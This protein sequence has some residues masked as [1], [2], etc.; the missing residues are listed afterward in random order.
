[1]VPAVFGGLARRA[2]FAVLAAV[3][4]L[5]MGGGEKSSF[6]NFSRASAGERDERGQGG[7]WGGG[8]SGNGW[9]GGNWGGAGGGNSGWGGGNANS[10]NGNGPNPPPA[11]SSGSGGP[12]GGGN[13]SNSGTHNES[14]GVSYDAAKN[15]VRLHLKLGDSGHS[16]TATAPG[17]GDFDSRHTDSHGHLLTSHFLRGRPVDLLRGHSEKDNRK[18][19]GRPHTERVETASAQNANALQLLNKAVNPTANRYE[20]A[21]SPYTAKPEPFTSFHGK[22]GLVLG[23]FSFLPHEIL[24]VDIDEPAKQRIRALGFTVGPAAGNASMSRLYAPPGMDAVH[25][26]QLLSKELPGH[27][28]ELNKVYRLYRAAMWEE[29]GSK[30]A[31]KAAAQGPCPAERCFARELIQWHDKLS[32]CAR[33]L[34]VGIID[35][36]IDRGHPAFKD[37][38]IH[39]GDFVQ[40]H[41]TTAPDWH[42]TGVL[43]L[44]AGNPSSGTPG[45]IPDAEFFAASVFFTESNGSMATDTVSL[46]AALKWMGDNGV[47]IVNMSIAGPRDDLVREKIEE[48]SGKGMIFVAAAGNEGPLADPAYPAAYPEVIAVTAVTQDKRNYRYANRGGHIDVA[49]P[50]V[51]IWTAVPG[52]KEGYHSG[53]SFAAPH[54]TGILALLPRD[55]PSANK[56]DILDGLPVV[57]LGT[58]GR[59]PVYGRGLLVA[60]SFCTPPETV[61]SA[62]SLQDQPAR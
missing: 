9:N 29:A 33:G 2:G 8:N 21:I 3:F 43:A 39:T 7:G 52:G 51:D 28:F 45:L 27:R 44:L 61:A 15:M 37:R 30:A 50:G 35:T 20:Q 16:G 19:F 38:H 57:D 13:G 10:G 49:A 26:Q 60:P 36:V 41:G 42:G 53:T 40:E 23:G 62:G 48:L 6:V 12:G 55:N 1:M 32:A 4:F 34:R 46:I 56:N 24:G 18:L 58:P 25:G 17:K 59:D 14:H 54:V 11:G 22:T 47:K 31:N 5:A